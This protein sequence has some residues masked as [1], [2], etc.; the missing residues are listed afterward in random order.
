[1]AEINLQ[2]MNTYTNNNRPITFQARQDSKVDI[3]ALKAKVLGKTEE[4]KSPTE[5]AAQKAKDGFAEEP[6]A[7][8]SKATDSLADIVKQLKEALIGLSKEDTSEEDKKT[9]SDALKGFQEELGKYVNGY[10]SAL[11][12]VQSSQRE[13]L[14]SGGAEMVTRTASVSDTLKQIGVN[15]EDDNTLSLVKKLD[16]K[17]AEVT[18]ALNAYNTLFSGGYSYGKKTVNTIDA[19]LGAN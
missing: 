17:Q 5:D 11:K 9:V 7:T 8:D 2:A 18:N 12:F 4:T 15:I 19:L 10:N 16:E 13:S 6:A 1:M 14:L 3:D